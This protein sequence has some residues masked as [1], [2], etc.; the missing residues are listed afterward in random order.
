MTFLAN[1]GNGETYKMTLTNVTFAPEYLTT[2]VSWK[3]LKRKGIK[4]NSE[5]NIMTYQ[6]NLICQLINCHDHDVFT[7]NPIPENVRQQC[8]SHNLSQNGSTD[9][10]QLSSLINSMQTRKSSGEAQLWHQRLGHA[11]PEALKHIKSDSVTMIDEGPKTHEC[12]Y[13]AL[14]KAAKVISRR[15]TEHSKDL[16]D[17]IHFDLISYSPIEFDGSRYVMHFTN[18]MT[19]MDYVY[20]LAN[21]SGDTLLCHFKN[22]VAYIKRQFEK[23]VKII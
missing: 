18:D 1:K 16:F 3:M 13:C 14:N 4:W 17:K 19:R 20:L 12:K 21:K 15:T 11:G 2:V 10:K 23:D 6:G 8:E 22:F 7:E 9:E 5:T